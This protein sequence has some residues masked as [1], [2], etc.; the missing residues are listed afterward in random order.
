MTEAECVKEFGKRKAAL[1]KYDVSEDDK[2]ALIGK[3]AKVYEVFDKTARKVVFCS[4][5]YN[6]GQ[7][8]ISEV[9]DPYK[10]ENFFPHPKPLFG[11]MTSNKLIPVPLYQILQDLFTELN[12]VQRRIMHLTRMLKVRGAYNGAKQ[13]TFQNILQSDDGHLEPIEQWTEQMEKGGMTGMIS[14]MPLG[15]IISALQTLQ[16][17]RVGIIQQINDI[18]GYTDAAR[19]STRT[20]ESA[21]ASKIKN[22]YLSTRINREVKKVARFVRDNLRLMAEMIGEHFQA[23]TVRQ[24]TGKMISDEEFAELRSDLSRAYK[25]D[26]ETDSMLQEDEEVEAEERSK[27]TNSIA[28]LIQAFAPIAQTQPFM[29]EGIKQIILWTVRGTK[30]GR[31]LEKQLQGLSFAPP[32]MPPALPDDTGGAEPPTDGNAA[33]M[34]Q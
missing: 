32:P 22:Q 33:P 2:K 13:D 7:G 28:T 12:E 11:T 19:G 29:G 10:L 20:A 5:G 21:A 23:E 25:I 6:G 8:T 27:V 1:L 14:F 30:R 4:P 16:A 24:I 34:P 17:N 3:Y 15:E 26:V 31:E 9:D 18:S